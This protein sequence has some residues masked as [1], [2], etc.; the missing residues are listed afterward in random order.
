[1]LQY[2]FHCLN[3]QLNFVNSYIYDNFSDGNI[4]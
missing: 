3:D 2:G 1:M 4:S